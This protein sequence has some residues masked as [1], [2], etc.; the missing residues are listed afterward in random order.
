MVTEPA[1]LRIINACLSLLGQTGLASEA[2]FHPML[3][4]AQ[5]ILDTELRSSLIPGYWF[6]THD[7]VSLAPMSDGR[8]VVPQDALSLIPSPRYP[9]Q[10]MVAQ[11]GRFLWGPE[12]SD[13]WAGPVYLRI[14]RAIGLEDAPP[15]FQ[16]YVGVRTESAFGTA[17]DADQ[18]KLAIVNARLQA[19][20]RE[21][22]REDVR[23]QA[24]NSHDT[25]IYI[26]A[27][28]SGR[29]GLGVRRGR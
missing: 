19:A 23:Q 7:P 28:T 16:D 1:R 14:V 3:G 25:N 22:D 17:F 6:N 4:D 21:L 29:Y 12:G 20:K 24:W 13:I 11:V 27:R 8:I 18:G 10:G 26:Q 9:G 2:E 5:R 15:S